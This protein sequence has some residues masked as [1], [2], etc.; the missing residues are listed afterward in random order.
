MNNRKLLAK[1]ISYM[2]AAML[3]A[4]VAVAG[5]SSGPAPD[6]SL[7]SLDGS[8]VRLSDL[9]GQVVLINFWATWCAPCREEMPLLDAIYQKYNRLGVELLGINVED[10]ASGAQKYLN[11]TPVTF[12][13]LFDP[14]CRVSKQYQV[15]AMPSTILVDRHGNVRHIHYGYKPGYENDY[16]DQIRALV[17][18]K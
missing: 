11:E 16:Q 7:Q 15:K 13:I 17:R 1:R 4:T 14:D 5:S 10:D 12:P 3:L 9:K 2:F 8:T 18:E 6:F